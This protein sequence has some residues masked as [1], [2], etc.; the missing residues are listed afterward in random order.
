MDRLLIPQSSTTM[1]R[2]GFGCARIFGGRESHRG[3][4]LIEA[5]LGLGIRHFDTAPAYGSED[6]LG[7]VLAGV[8]DVTIATKIGLPRYAGERSAAKKYLGPLYRAS[9]RPLLGRVPGLKSSLLKIASMP[10]SHDA[11]MVKRQLGREEV[12]R[13]LEESLR[14]LRRSTIDLYLLHE[15]EGI[16]ITDELRE[17][18]ASLRKD[19]VIRASGL[20]F[21]ALPSGSSSFGCVVQSR[22]PGDPSFMSGGGAIRIFHGVVRYGIRDRTK[23]GKLPDA[24]KLI[25]EALRNDPA[26]AVVFSAGAKHQIRQ[27]ADACRP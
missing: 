23:D 10:R 27:I 11:P 8:P 4:T 21:G 17:V 26:A 20:A 24:G 7:T 16:D 9:L 6:V 22:Y 1:C 3:A 15:P 5:A 12:L 2:L 25:A 14:R 13:E 18:F 19:G